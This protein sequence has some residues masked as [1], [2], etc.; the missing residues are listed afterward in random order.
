LGGGP[1]AWAAAAHVEAGYPVYATPDAARTF[2]DDLDE[3]AQMGVE[4]VGEDE[5]AELQNVERV[6]MQDLDV[7]AIH[8]ALGLFGVDGGFD[9]LAV[10]A[11]DHGNAPVGYSDRQFRFDYLAE[12]LRARNHLAAFAF[13]R[14]AIP[15]VMT[16]LLAVAQ[17]APKDVPLFVMDT[18]PAA[19]L[20][21]LE[22]L[23]VAAPRFSVVVNVGNFHT[24]AFRLCDGQIEGLFE[25]HTGL[26]T[27]DKLEALLGQLAEGT[28][29]HEE[30]F[31]DH[32]HGALM[33]DRQPM[34]LDFLAVTGPRRSLLK[35]SSYRPY[36]A[37][38]Y[39]DMMMAGC[40]GMVRAL[41]ESWPERQEEIEAALEAG[42]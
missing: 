2:N 11:F 26:L 32:G 33:F 24:L 9:A 40:W 34:P 38:P 42:S 25:H 41:A 35:G 20:G 29:C 13:W 8:R 15:P 37:V 30:L 14:D 27:R 3:V 18:A 39:G 1:C 19:V 31:T 6:T 16:R 5:A 21:A 22:D 28:L 17:T 4:V 36:M 12:R 23:R 10:A 7:E